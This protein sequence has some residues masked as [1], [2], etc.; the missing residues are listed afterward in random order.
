[1]HSLVNK[2][3]ILSHITAFVPFHFESSSDQFYFCRLIN[4]LIRLPEID[5]YLLR[6]ASICQPINALVF[7]SVTGSTMFQLFK[8]NHI[9]K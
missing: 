8:M 5:K 3:H 1:M 6:V 2:R 9:V 7:F 4:R